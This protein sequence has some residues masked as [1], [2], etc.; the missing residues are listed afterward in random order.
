MWD[1]CRF[2]NKK[3]SNTKNLIQLQ[4]LN[5]IEAVIGGLIGMTILPIICVALVNLVPNSILFHS[6]TQ[7]IDKVYLV[8]TNVISL[9]L[10]A[11]LGIGVGY[12]RSASSIYFWCDGRCVK[13]MHI[14]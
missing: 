7:F 12:C 6:D 1:K 3:I 2:C 9:F 14:I 8:Y 4:I 13:V 11:G 5:G 10:C